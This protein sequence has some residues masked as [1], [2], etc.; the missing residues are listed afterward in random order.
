MAIQIATQE[1]TVNIQ[2]TPLHFYI[3]KVNAPGL[4]DF[5]FMQISTPS[6]VFQ[7]LLPMDLAERVHDLLGR[8]L[9]AISIVPAGAMP[10]KPV[11]G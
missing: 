4:G 6:G 2:P 9:K 11:L 7:H 10:S 5:M 3:E 1:Q 8:N